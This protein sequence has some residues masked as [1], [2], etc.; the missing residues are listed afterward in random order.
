MQSKANVNSSLPQRYTG[1]QF[2]T[3]KIPSYAQFLSVGGR[4]MLLL[5]VFS[6]QPGR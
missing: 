3:T 4:G 5:A 2:Y 6:G 1:S